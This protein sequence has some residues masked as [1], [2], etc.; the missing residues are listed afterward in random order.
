MAVN[1]YTAFGGITAQPKKSKVAP[2]QTGGV[3]DEKRLQAH[4]HQHRGVGGRPFGRFALHGMHIDLRGQ[5]S[6]CRR[7]GNDGAHMRR[8]VRRKDLGGAGGET[9]ARRHV[10]GRIR[11]PALGQ[12]GTE[13]ARGD[14]GSPRNLYLLLRRISLH[15]RARRDNGRDHHRTAQRTQDDGRHILHRNPADTRAS[16]GEDRARGD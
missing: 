11:A 15:E 6:D 8:L 1:I 14:T 2:N 13:A 3:S 7:I 10:Q 5:G 9:R 12:G 16:K 4:A